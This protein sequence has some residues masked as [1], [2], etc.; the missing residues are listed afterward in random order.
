MTQGHVFDAEA[1][2][3]KLNPAH[4]GKVLSPFSDWKL[5]CARCGMDVSFRGG[6]D[7]CP[8]C[9]GEVGTTTEYT[10]SPTVLKRVITCRTCGYQAEYTYSDGC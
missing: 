9:F 10:D 4:G 6:H 1:V 2:R 5:K 7:Y 3:K 8:V